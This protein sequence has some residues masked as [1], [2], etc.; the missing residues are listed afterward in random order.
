MNGIK[1]RIADAKIAC[2]DLNLEKETMKLGVYIT[3]D[4]PT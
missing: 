3:I 1:T 2:L 4:D